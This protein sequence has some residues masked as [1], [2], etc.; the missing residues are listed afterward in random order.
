MT[1]F[2]HTDTKPFMHRPE[3]LAFETG[4]GKPPQG[5]RFQPGQSGNP[6]GRPKGAKNKIPALNGGR[7]KDIIM[8]E[9]NRTISVRD[10]EKNVTMPMVRTVIRSLVVSAD[11]GNS[12]AQRLFTGLLYT[13]EREQ[14]A[15]EYA[16]LDAVIGYKVDWEREL[17]RR[18]RLGIEAPE[19]F[20]HPDQIIVDL[21]GDGGITIKGPMTKQEKT[22]ID[23]EIDSVRRAKVTIEAGLEDL[24]GKPGGARSDKTRKRLQ[25]RIRLFER[26]LHK[27][28]TRL[29]D[30]EY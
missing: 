2:R 10:G 19:P 7:L 9:A 22:E 3:S 5:S 24:Q 17:E 8:E 15:Q 4:Y 29:S 18:A 11:K 23:E 1:K 14:A 26:I 25:N 27:I 13:T 12:R 6:G 20:P 30:L 16:L 28:R 21:R